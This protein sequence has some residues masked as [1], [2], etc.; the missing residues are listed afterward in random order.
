MTFNGPLEA[1]IRAVAVLGFA[2][3]QRFDIHRLTAYDYLLVRTSVIDGPADLHPPVPIQAPATEVRRK[4]VQDALNI[5]MTR[6]LIVRYV[7]GDGF[8]YGAGDSAAIF[9]D[10]MT[11]PYLFALKE[12]AAWLTSR[13]ENLDDAAFE[14]M[15]SGLF[16]RWLVELQEPQGPSPLASS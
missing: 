3:P 12:R 10:S 16:D 11:T 4:V 9:L 13:L 5:M 14:Q 2:Y 6:D 7:S 1:G 8:E 15:M